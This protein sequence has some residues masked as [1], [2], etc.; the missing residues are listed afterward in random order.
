[1]ESYL[2]SISTPRGEVAIAEI[3]R[4]KS[5]LTAERLYN[6][7]PLQGRVIKIGNSLRLYVDLKVGV[8]K[9]TTKVRAGELAY[10]PSEKA[11]IFFFEDYT[12]PRPVNILGVIKDGIS[13]LKELRTGD[14]IRIGRQN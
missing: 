3:I 11:L 8:E 2:I 5:P 10:S 4:Y 9:A 14:S 6:S 12:P 7:L 1:M 13:F